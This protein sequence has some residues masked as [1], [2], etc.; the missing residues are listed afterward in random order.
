ML[1]VTNKHLNQNVVMLSVIILNAITLNV[2]EPKIYLS[3][4]FPMKLI[5]LYERTTC[6]FN[7][8]YYWQLFTNLPNIVIIYSL[9]T[10]IKTYLQVQI[11]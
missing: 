3:M 10:K 8:I 1:S 5:M 11:Y 4:F 6:Q 2:T 9:S 7:Q